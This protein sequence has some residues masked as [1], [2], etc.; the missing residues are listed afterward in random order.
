MLSKTFL[1]PRLGPA[2][3]VTIEAIDRAAFKRQFHLKRLF[4]KLFDSSILNERG[5]L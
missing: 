4:E 3:E 5:M 2:N 1:L